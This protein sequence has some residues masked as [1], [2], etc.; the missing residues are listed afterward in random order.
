MTTR[1]PARPLPHSARSGPASPAC[2]ASRAARRDCGLVYLV[3]TDPILRAEL[4]RRTLERRSG[5][6]CG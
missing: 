3:M 5:F 2:C 4:R 6:R 1:R